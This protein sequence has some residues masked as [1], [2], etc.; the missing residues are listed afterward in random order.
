MYLKSTNTNNI[1][2]YHNPQCS[3]AKKAMAYAQSVAGMVMNMEFSK[4][5][6][7]ATQWRELLISLGKSPKEILD[8]ST[9][10]YQQNLRGRNFPDEDWLNVII[11]NPGLIRSP[12][13]VKGNKVM[14][15]DNPS[16]ILHI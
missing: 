2:L 3:K 7:T 13:A 4:T 16:D 6:K 12:I 10:Y 5:G 15:L 9:Q 11:K 14:L 8:K 1:T